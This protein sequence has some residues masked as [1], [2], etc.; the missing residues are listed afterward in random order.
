MPQT[1]WLNDM[2][3]EIEGM[4]GPRAFPAKKKEE[5]AT[6]MIVVAIFMCVALV[7]AYVYR[8]KVGGIGDSQMPQYANSGYDPSYFRQQQQSQLPPA[9]FQE[10]TVTRQEMDAQQQAL[11]KIWDR[12]KWLTDITTLNAILE[13]HN[14]QVT[15]RGYPKSHYIHLNEDWT[16]NRVPEYVQLT[17]QDRAWIQ[18]FV[19]R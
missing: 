4:T 9:R 15:Q 17:P 13:N 7:A 11:V 14:L 6:S 16:I 12:T 18:K 3:N 1:A 19:R 10:P 2:Q 5:Y 8:T